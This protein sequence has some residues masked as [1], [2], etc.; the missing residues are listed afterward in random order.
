MDCRQ[1][2]VTAKAAGMKAIIITAKHYDG[3]CL[4]SSAF[5]THTLRQSSWRNGEGDLLK[6]FS[7]ACRDH[8]LKLGILPFAVGQKPPRLRHK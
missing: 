4:W 5:S 1:W 7:D 3:F 6:E 2:A 8:G